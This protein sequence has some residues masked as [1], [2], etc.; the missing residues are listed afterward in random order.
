MIGLA[1]LL[2]GLIGGYYGWLLSMFIR[3]E[4]GLVGIGITRT[5]GNMHN[6]NHAISAHG[7]LMIFYFVMPIMIGLLGNL[8]IPVKIGCAELCMPRLN[9]LSIWFYVWSVLMLVWGVQIFDKCLASGWTLY[10]PLSTR[11]FAST[12]H[13]TDISIFAVHF[14]GVS[15]TMASMNMLI[16]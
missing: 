9:G 16:T 15:S 4:M 7:L 12:E 11:D 14:L 13:S 6:Y 8:L 3:F 1:Y 2:G 5:I 10:P